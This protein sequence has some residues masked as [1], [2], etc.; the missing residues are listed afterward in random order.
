VIV[1]SV[2]CNNKVPL[3][4]PLAMLAATRWLAPWTRNRLFRKY[5]VPFVAVVLGAVLMNGIVEIYFT[6][7]EARAQVAQIQR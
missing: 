5:V 1:A 4:Y 7:T 6:Y 2:R 3:R